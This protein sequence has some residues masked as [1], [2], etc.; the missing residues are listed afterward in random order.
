MCAIGIPPC[1]FFTQAALTLIVI[2]PQP[3]EGW[4]YK[5]VAIR[6][7]CITTFRVCISTKI[8]N[9]NLLGWFLLE[10]LYD[11]DERRKKLIGGWIHTDMHG[12]LEGQ[13]QATGRQLS[14][15]RQVTSI[16]KFPVIHCCTLRTQAETSSWA[17]K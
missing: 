5:S 3:L 2:L 7:N 14:Q 11:K 9:E 10:L 13:R 15:G 12:G 6:L 16:F 17:N 1:L 4:G 8:L